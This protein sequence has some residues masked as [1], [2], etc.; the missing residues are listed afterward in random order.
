MNPFNSNPGGSRVN[1]TYISKRGESFTYIYLIFFFFLLT[2]KT[3]LS[4][5][6]K[7]GENFSFTSIRDNLN[8]FNLYLPFAVVQ[9]LS[10]VQLFAVWQASLFFMIFQSLLKL[11]SIESIM[12]STHLI[13]CHSLLLLPSI[14]SGI[15][16]F[17]SESALRIRWPKYKLQLPHQ[18][19]Q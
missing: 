3:I 1:Y 8:L 19:F 12:P 18:S 9:L 14:F 11:M 7:K 16:V 4:K 6:P 17:S 13:R 15:R 2:F 10:C 5:C